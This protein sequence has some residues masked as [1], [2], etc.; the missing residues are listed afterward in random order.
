MFIALVMIVKVASIVCTGVAGIKSQDDPA[1]TTTTTAA[2]ENAAV[3]TTTT[4]APEN[5]EETP[6]E[7]EHTELETKRFSSFVFLQE[8]QLP[9][10]RQ[11]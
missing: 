3:T 6:A 10:T 11:M 9:P 2:V 4:A 1:T 8:L 5:A 7:G